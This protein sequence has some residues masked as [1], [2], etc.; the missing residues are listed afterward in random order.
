M[1]V[2][3]VMN[4]IIK[5]KKGFLRIIEASIAIVLI[6]GVLFTF[7]IK[8][9]V[10]EEPDLSERARD[11]L[12]EISRNA[13]LRGEIL[14]YDTQAEDPPDP[15]PDNVNASVIM[16]IPENY[17]RYEVKICEVLDVCGKSEYFAGN[18]YTGE[19]I[20]SSNITNIDTKK[21]KLFIWQETG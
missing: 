12:E 7:Y 9:R 10:Q 13:T 18:V 20:I 11:I 14:N 8:D 15:I 6:M 4:K 2:K 19:R 5:N 21:I 16:R 17:L 3:M 1:V